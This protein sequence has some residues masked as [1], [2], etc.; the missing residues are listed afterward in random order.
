MSVISGAFALKNIWGCRSGWLAVRLMK[1]FTVDS[2]APDD[3]YDGNDG[4]DFDKND[5]GSDDSD[6]D[7]HDGNDCDGGSDSYS[8]DKEDDSSDDDDCNDGISDGSGSERDI[9]NGSDNNHKGWN[10]EGD[11]DSDDNDSDVVIKWGN[12]AVWASSC[13]DESETRQTAFSC[14]EHPKKIQP[15]FFTDEVEGMTNKKHTLTRMY[16][17]TAVSRSQYGVQQVHHPKHL[18]FR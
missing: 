12:H 10:D 9:C 6:Y 11:G 3:C 13:C 2:T 1:H 16:V 7:C 14:T 8:D 4:D 17:R 18:I 5:D 15:Y